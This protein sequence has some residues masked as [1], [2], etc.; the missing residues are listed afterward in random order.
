MDQLCNPTRESAGAG[1]AVVG[2]LKEGKRDG[3]GHCQDQLGNVGRDDRYHPLS[4]Q[5]L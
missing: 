2:P 4:H 5:F 3:D 1:T